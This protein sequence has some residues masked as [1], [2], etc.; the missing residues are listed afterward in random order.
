MRVVLVHPAVTDAV[1]PR[2]DI[3][4]GFGG[5]LP[6]LAGRWP[7][8]GVGY[9]AAVLE[10][11]TDHEVF[12]VDAEVEDLPAERAA[13]RILALRPDVIGLSC[14]TFSYVYLYALA[15]LL[16][17][18]TDAPIIIGGYHVQFYPKEIVSHRRFDVAVTGEGEITLAEIV[19]CIDR[20]GPRGYRAHLGAIA[21]VAFLDERGDVRQTEARDALGDLDA[22]PHPARHLLRRDLYRQNHLPPPCTA[23]VTTRGCPFSCSFCS[24]TRED[25]IARYHSPEYV[26]DEV[27]AVAE[28]GYRSFFVYDDTFTLHKKRV[29]A[30]ANGI[31]A[32]RLG[33]T[34]SAQ[35]RVELFTDEVAEALAAAG[36]EA[37]SFGIESGDEG[38][39]ERL[40][41]R[42]TLEDARRAFERCRKHGM[43]AIC[44][45]MVGIPEETPDAF[46]NT[47]AFLK[48]TKPD[49]FKAN[50]LVPYP[51]SPLYRDLMARGKIDDIWG[52]MTLTGRA[53]DRPHVSEHFTPGELD[54][55]RN[56][57]NL[58]PYLRR[59]TN[60][61]N[62]W[63][64]VRQPSVAIESLRYVLANLSR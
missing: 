20:F 60:L 23:I 10:R 33:L 61:L 59:R 21:G 43:R 53:P 63:R 57:I 49:W 17:E 13:A 29:I 3:D 51:G 7:P 31:A 1:K 2:E 58:M 26:V 27:T 41:K 55:M 44:G 22:L 45:I 47:K 15:G 8:L 4:S 52:I 36:C 35:T 56:E 5:G 64:V 14:M 48:A 11:D 38:M 37:M 39:L 9:I 46:E 62:V 19:A 54:G 24:R 34:W 40:D 28:A 42:N 18:A 30:L 6:R 16:E 32:R 50:I 12:I 25:R